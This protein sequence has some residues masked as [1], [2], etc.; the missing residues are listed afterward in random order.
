MNNKVRKG[1][2]GKSAFEGIPKNVFELLYGKDI[3]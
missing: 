1:K 3:T 2:G